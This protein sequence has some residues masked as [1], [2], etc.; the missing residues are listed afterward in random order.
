[1]VTHEAQWNGIVTVVRFA[2]VVYSS[3]RYVEVPI[4]GHRDTNIPV[5]YTHLD[6]YKRQ[7]LYRIKEELNYNLPRSK[8]NFSHKHIAAEII[9]AEAV[10]K[11]IYSTIQCLSLIHI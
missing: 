5:S 1:M 10:V 11:A 8:S 6:V 9:N 2:Q 3:P 7:E 4:L